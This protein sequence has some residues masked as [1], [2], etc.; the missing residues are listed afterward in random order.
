MESAHVATNANQ[1][2]LHVF[3]PSWLKDGKNHITSG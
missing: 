2:E 3:V 1:K